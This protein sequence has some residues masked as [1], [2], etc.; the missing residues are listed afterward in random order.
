MFQNKTMKQ[1]KLRWDIFMSRGQIFMC[2]QKCFLEKWLNEIVKQA[3]CFAEST[4]T[5]FAQDD[6]KYYNE[7]RPDALCPILPLWNI[8]SEIKIKA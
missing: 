1:R 3:N 2:V 4:G 6:A 7:N 5:E 8:R